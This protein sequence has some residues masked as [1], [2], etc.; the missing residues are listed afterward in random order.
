M[1]GLENVKITKFHVNAS[2]ELYVKSAGFVVGKTE[3]SS[4]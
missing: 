3:F 1:H 4:W 2:K